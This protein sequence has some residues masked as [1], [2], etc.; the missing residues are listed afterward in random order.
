MRRAME[1]VKGDLL[2]IEFQHVAGLVEL[3]GGPAGHG[4]MQAPGI[5]AMRSFEWLRIARPGTGGAVGRDYRLRLIVPG[6]T[7]LPG[8]KCLIRTETIEKSETMGLGNSV[9]NNEMGCLDLARVTGPLE[10]RNWQPGDQYRPTGHSSQLKIKTLFQNSRVPL[11]ERRHWPVVVQ[12]S[13]IVWTRRFGA[14]AHLMPGPETRWVLAIRER[15][16]N[17]DA[18]AKRLS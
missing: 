3:A 15:E 11:W 13:E 18:S 17:L 14:A 10:L 9:Y 7:W 16:E 8:C 2:G 5:D 1:L 6:E 4:R 12:G